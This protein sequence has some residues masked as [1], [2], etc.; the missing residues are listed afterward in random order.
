M[1][2]SVITG[3]Q[4]GLNQGEEKF[5]QLD[6]DLPVRIICYLAAEKNVCV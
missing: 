4:K 3:A 5:R 6:L 1:V 2:G